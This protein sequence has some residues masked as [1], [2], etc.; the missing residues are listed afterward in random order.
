MVEN[1]PLINLMVMLLTALLIVFIP[2]K[3]FKTI[4]IIGSVSLSVVG[5]NSV[6]ILLHT[7][8][9]GAFS[10]VF[11][12]HAPFLGV[13]MRIDVFAALFTLFIGVLALLT[14][15]YSV[16]YVHKE[17]EHNQTP[18]YYVLMFILFFAA[19]GIIYTH[20]LFNTYVFMEILSI[21]AC[22]IVSIKRKRR[23]YMA[24]FRYLILNEIGS[25]SFLFGVALL[26]MITGYT[27]I[28][29]VNETLNEVWHLYP[30]NIIVAA[31][32]MLT[33]VAIKA[34]IFPF[35]VWLPD[36]HSSAPIP[37]HAIL[38]AV[39]LKLNLL[40]FV[41]ILYQVMGPQIMT[42]L[43]ISPFITLIAA[44][45]MIMG[46]I[47]AIAQHDIKRILAYS[48]VAQ[49]GY[50]VLGISL[51]S[52]L[53]QSAAYYHVFSHGMMKSALFFSAGCII[54]ATNIRDVRKYG[55]LF[56]TMPITVSVFSIAA[57]GM[58]GIPLTSG[59]LSKYYLGMA[60]MDGH[61]PILVGVI[62]LSSI[63]NAVY[64]LPI[65]IRA[66]LYD[67]A[68]EESLSLDRVPMSM[69]VPVGIFGGM[70]LVLGIYPNVLL[71]WIESALIVALGGWM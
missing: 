30:A 16:G 29:L 39:V 42:E 10:Y 52:P 58:I 35:H 34:A 12:N 65:V 62:I 24:A 37:S 33:G 55:G 56:K 59:F 18:R 23:N 61:L 2:I 47:F 51:M 27:N 50:I 15:I 53:G 54:Y 63:L 6:W 40:V 4:K 1:L 64:Y 69:L 71:E 36:A 5:V 57:M 25:L 21:T 8:Q 68:E 38:S 60:A 11:G 19:Y 66:L 49:V 45:A 43:N 26:Y 32:F 7:L 3:G 70:T 17:V 9:N 13:E 41:K 44:A 22:G 48:S 28:T 14:F 67:N 46:S 20:D 31:G